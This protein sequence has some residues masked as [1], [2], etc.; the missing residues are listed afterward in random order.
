MLPYKFS[1]NT[2]VCVYTSLFYKRSVHSSRPTTPWGRKVRWLR[3]RRQ[4]VHTLMPSCQSLRQRRRNSHSFPRR[5]WC[6]PYRQTDELHQD[7][8]V[9][10][11]VCNDVDEL[12]L[13][14]ENKMKE[15]AERYATLLNIEFEWPSNAL[16]EVPPTASP[17]PSV[18]TT[19]I[20]KAFSKMKCD[21]AAIPS[22]LPS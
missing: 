12:V 17:S 15:W 9:E 6:V 21:K 8:V 18:S 5:W 13:T 10:N 22:H 20:H 14:D 16:F 7:G 4:K 3:P 11:C 1:Q 19:L 2:L